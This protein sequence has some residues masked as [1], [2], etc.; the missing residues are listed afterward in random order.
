M[1]LSSRIVK[2]NLQMEGRNK[3]CK[4]RTKS[5]TAGERFGCIPG[6]SLQGHSKLIIT[7]FIYC[8]KKECVQNVF[9][10]CI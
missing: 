3:I 7:E 5:R 2:K 8:I 4:H 10:W 1:L 6:N 9:S